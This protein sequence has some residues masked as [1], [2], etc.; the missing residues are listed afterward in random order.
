LTIVPNRGG[1]GVSARSVHPNAAARF[2]LTGKTAWVVGG[3]GVL[4]TPVSHALAEHGA[5]VVIADIRREKAEALAQAICAENLSAESMTLDAGDEAAIVRAADDIVVR[6]GR[7]DVVVGMAYFYTKTAME[8]MTTSEWERGM[9]VTL[10]GA[11]VL[12]REAGRIMKEGGGGSIIQFSSMYGLVSPDPRMYPPPHQINPI[13]YGVAK[14]GVL[15][16]VRYQAVMLAPHKVRV[17]AICPGPFP[18]PA[19]QGADPEFL[20]R[21]SKK[22]PMGRVGRG[23]EMAGAVVYLAS[24][25]SSYVTGTQLVVDGGWCAW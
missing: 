12:G 5:H 7:I 17:N 9:R 14:A 23:S 25:A 13:D 1:R 15:Q 18:D 2:S 21:L 6:R 20:D 22:S 4:G 24:D 8:Q 10:T 16:M 3:A 11:F 19:T